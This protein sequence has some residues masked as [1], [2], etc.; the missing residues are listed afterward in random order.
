MLDPEKP[1]VINE[2]RQINNKIIQCFKTA[3]EVLVFCKIKQRRS[4]KPT[5]SWSR[6]SL[7]DFQKGLYYSQNFNK[8]I[9][10][11]FQSLITI[12][13][14]LKQNS[15]VIPSR[16]KFIYFSTIIVLNF[17]LILA[18][19]ESSLLLGPSVGV[20]NEFQAHKLFLPLKIRPQCYY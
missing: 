14:V 6:D 17:I 16:I 4:S 11:C 20:F 5:K 7:C 13:P 1:K 2:I 9:A 10:D 12:K 18:G 3:L 8:C 15:S 19:E